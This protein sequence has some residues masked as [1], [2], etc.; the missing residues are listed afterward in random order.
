MRSTCHQ[1]LQQSPCPTSHL[2]TMLKA[3]R[4]F[5]AFGNPR[6]AW[7]A[8]TRLDFENPEYR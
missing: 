3:N 7:E 4:G 6:A 1:I 8:G 2:A 5:P